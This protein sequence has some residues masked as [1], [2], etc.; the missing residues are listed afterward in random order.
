MLSYLCGV[1]FQAGALIRRKKKKK[2]EEA[3]APL[4]L[5]KE[6]F[7]SQANS[8]KLQRKY[9]RTHSCGAAAM[10]ELMLMTFT[11]SRDASVV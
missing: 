1:Y 8:S 6:W 11:C 10:H 3:Y 9:P 5:L 7:H 4:P 2:E